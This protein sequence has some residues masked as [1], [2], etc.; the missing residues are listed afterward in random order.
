MS[1]DEQVI[2]IEAGFPRPETYRSVRE[3]PP[4]VH[5]DGITWGEYCASIGVG[6][7]VHE[8]AVCPQCGWS[9]VTLRGDRCECHRAECRYVW[10]W[11]FAEMGLD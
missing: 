2:V 3:T 9:G 4:S 5:E 8:T 1:D 11:P 10:R 7:P 6:L